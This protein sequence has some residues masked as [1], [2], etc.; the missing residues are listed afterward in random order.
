MLNSFWLLTAMLFMG[1]AYVQQAAAPVVPAIPADA[2]AMTNPVKS[3][4]ESMAHAK[5][6]YGYDCA[7][8]HGDNGKGKG[9][10]AVQMKLSTKDWSGPGALKGKTDGELFYIIR[11][12]QGQMPAEGERAKPE[13]VWSM[14]EMVRGF[15]K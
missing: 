11:N 1:P 3:T 8:C 4:P 14:V 15:S 9:E 6:I 7:V 10:L 12:G 2:V 5:K 13:D